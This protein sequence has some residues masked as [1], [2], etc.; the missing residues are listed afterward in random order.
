MVD[1]I[2]KNMKKSILFLLCIVKLT[3]LKK[4]ITS[5]YFKF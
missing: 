3:Y 5:V 2:K 1:K 4:K